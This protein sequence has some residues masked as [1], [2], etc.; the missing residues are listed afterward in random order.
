MDRREIKE[1][2]AKIASQ[3]WF[4]HHFARE[5]RKLSQSMT[6]EEVKAL[7]RQMGNSSLEDKFLAQWR[8]DYPQLPE[9]LPQYVFAK[10]RKWPFDF[11]WPDHGKLA[12]E[13]QGGSFIGGAHARA[14]Q[15][16]RDFEKINTA[17]MMGWR[18]LQFNTQSLKDLAGCVELTAQALCRVMP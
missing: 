17:Q 18:V 14:V 11:A 15:Q 3:N 9:P 1:W 2:A 10:P 5:I 6:A 16:A 7:A 8:L 4:K 13:I 12:V